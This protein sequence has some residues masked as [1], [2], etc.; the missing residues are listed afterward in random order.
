MPNYRQSGANHPYTGSGSS[1]L[2][3]TSERIAA[4]IAAFNQAGGHIE[5]L[6]NTPF[7]HRAKESESSP[8]ENGSAKIA[9]RPLPARTSDEK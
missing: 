6:G 8:R 1:K 2:Q 9:A 3:L 7:H 4:D 5:V